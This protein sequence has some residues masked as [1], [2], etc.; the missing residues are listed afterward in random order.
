[1]R[2][3]PTDG[4][5]EKALREFW[6]QKLPPAIRTVVISL[7]GDLDS[8]AE[9]SDRIMD[10]TT[11]HKIAS[12]STYVDTDRLGRSTRTGKST[13]HFALDHAINVPPITPAKRQ[14]MFLS[15]RV[16]HRRAK[17][18]RTVHI[19]LRNLAETPEAPLP[20]AARLTRRV[21]VSDTRTGKQFLIESEAEISMLPPIAGARPAFD[22]VLTAANGT[23]IRTYGPKTLCLNLG[24][25]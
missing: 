14:L 4:I 8:V 10:A 5:G 24:V 18:S 13:P 20:S 7:D 22:I 19:S 17:M 12:V 11:S 21:F 1:M 15:Q 2:S 6:L 25:K 23:R 3:R 9:R 16:R